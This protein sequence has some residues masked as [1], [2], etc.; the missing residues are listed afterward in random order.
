MS[1]KVWY[2]IQLEC[3]KE[4]ASFTCKVGDIQTVAKVK[5]KGLAYQVALKLEEIYRKE[6]WKIS[7]V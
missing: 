6:Y 3:I 2:E 7:I 5:S 4:S 1:K